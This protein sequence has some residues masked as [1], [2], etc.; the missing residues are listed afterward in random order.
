[1]TNSNK[2]YTELKRKLDELLEWFDRDDIDLDEAV[3]K[4]KQGTELVKLLEQQLK[5]AEN[6]VS[7]IKQQFDQ[8]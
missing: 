8:K 4:Y 6:T 2:S 1:M 7:K 5:D 3:A